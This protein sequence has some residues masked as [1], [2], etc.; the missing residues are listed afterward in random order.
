MKC[1]RIFVR[2]LGVLN[3][4]YRKSPKRR[5]TDPQESV[6]QS[7]QGTASSNQEGLETASTE[8]T[9]DLPPSTTPRIVS[10]S[11]SSDPPDEVPQVM[12]ANNLH[13]IPENLFRGAD[14]AK[15]F[16]SWLSNDP[17]AYSSARAISSEPGISKEEPSTCGEENAPPQRPSLD[18]HPSWGATTVNTKLKEQVLREVF[19]PPPVH[20]HS[21]RTGR[22]PGSFRSHRGKP[23][24]TSH[25]RSYLE[26]TDEKGQSDSG[27]STQTSSTTRDMLDVA[28]SSAQ[29]MGVS[30]PDELPDL[31]LYKLEKIH[32][33]GSESSGSS[34][35]DMAG[36]MHRRRSASG[37]RRR[38]IDLNV[39]ERTN[40]QYYDDDGY[41]GDKEDEIFKFEHGDSEPRLR[42][43]SVVTNGV[44]S[45]NTPQ[46]NIDVP[47]QITNEQIKTSE[48]AI[49]SNRHII[50]PSPIHGP[51]NPLQAQLQA[52]LEPDER[53]RY[54]LLLEDL[55]ANMKH[56]CVL[57]LKMGTRQYG[58]F[59]NKKKQQSQRQKCKVTTSQE[60][61]VRL[62]GMQVWNIKKKQYIF[63]D[64]YAGR[65]LKAGRE[66][67]DALQRFLYDGISYTSVS[68][69]IPPL[70]EKL[71]KLE[72][73]ITKLPGYR[74]YASSLL[75]LYDGAATDDSTKLEDA[76]GISSDAADANPTSSRT[77]PLPSPAISPLPKQFEFSQPT[78]N[79]QRNHAGRRHHNLPTSSITIKLVDF[80][81]CVTPPLP[82]N[83]TPYCPPS[84]PSGIDRG[85]IRGL[86]T[87]RS[88]LQ[89]IWKD[90]EDEEWV[91]RG[92]G[93]AM[94]R[95][96][97]ALGIDG[98]GREGHKDAWDDDGEVSL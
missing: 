13:I 8:D 22:H 66:F 42:S 46:G 75:M 81:N 96:T 19:S 54:F 58:M 60:L 37:L 57:D 77:T 7:A 86:R 62:C 24:V 91:E 44:R 64:K 55:T 88:Y 65:D 78:P 59:A 33:T 5:R 15:G 2:Y 21:R 4:T 80:A 14:Q 56:P 67:R 26:I 68:R 76:G 52:Q 49:Q 71:T 9:R 95:G 69:H 41:G 40:L 70:I 73:I 50:Q 27:S 31:G 1:F 39:S 43:I 47:D 83:P 18:Q 87:L 16:N 93:E 82:S 74:F 79:P 45:N 89:R 61:G 94:A 51:L 29:S 6:Q 23:S 34:K 20:H 36:T 92:E 98:T 30:A 97:G 12:F 35:L 28:R 10:H 90:I 3:V 38:Q 25:P 32:T 48:L 63:E 17:N 53:V 11:Q 84:D 72:K 85:Y